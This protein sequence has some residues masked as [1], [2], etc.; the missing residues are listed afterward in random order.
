M[1]QLVQRYHDDLADAH[2]G[3]DAQT[4]EELAVNFCGAP[5]LEMERLTPKAP[6]ASH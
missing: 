2:P 5:L 4:L 3:V 6:A 1:E